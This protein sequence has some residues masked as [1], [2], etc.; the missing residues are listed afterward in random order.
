MPLSRWMFGIVHAALCGACL[1]LLTTVTAY[2]QD[3]LFEDQPWSFENPQPGKPLGP[4]ALADVDDDG[5]MDLFIGAYQNDGTVP[6]SGVVYV[7]YADENGIKQ[8]P[9][10]ILEGEQIGEGFGYSLAR[11][12][13]VNADNCDDV[14]IG[15]P[16]YDADPPGVKG[17]LL[18]DAGRATAFYGSILGIDPAFDWETFGEQEDENYGYNVNTAGNVNNDPY[19]DVIVGSPGFSPTIDLIAAG[20]FTI[21]LGSPDGLELLEHYFEFGEVTGGM[22]GYTVGPAYQ[23]DDDEY[24][25]IVAA[26]PFAEKEPDPLEDEGV[27]EFRYGSPTGVTKSKMRRAW[28]RGLRVNGRLGYSLSASRALRL[29]LAGQPGINRAM[30]IVPNNS[31]PTFPGIPDFG[32]WLFGPEQFGVS[33]NANFG[34]YVGIS[35]RQV[36]GQDLVVGVTAPL[37]DVN[38]TV[39]AGSLFFV[40]LQFTEPGTVEITP[41]R[42]FNGEIDSAALGLSCA[43]AS[44]RLPGLVYSRNV[45]A[46]GGAAYTGVIDYWFFIRR[47]YSYG[48]ALRVG[49]GTSPAAAATFGGGPLG[50]SSEA[51]RWADL[52]LLAVVASFVVAVGRRTTRRVTVRAH[53]KNR[54]EKD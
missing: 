22:L 33:P 8:I 25:D 5:Y 41:L 51:R 31:N 10:V 38:T 44:G 27:I 11:A 16:F 54:P 18:I 14:I 17:S 15:S 26:A 37:N 36:E 1:I 24:D 3:D 23:F 42:D 20:A 46:D 6:N 21:Y 9:D 12:G 19:D 7:F 13:D 43:G 35:S 39:E 32:F 53:D 40:G 48:G 34:A 4:A 28:K 50:S 52:A 45:L 30:G 47:T 29:V 49:C 2:A